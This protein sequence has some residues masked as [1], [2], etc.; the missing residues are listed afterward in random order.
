MVVL[1]LF[2]ILTESR[3]MAKW[4][5]TAGE[6]VVLHVL[7]LVIVMVFRIMEKPVLTVE[8]EGVELALL[9]IA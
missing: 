2:A 8:G 5:E 3:I 6:E 4:G 1:L 9:T 7:K